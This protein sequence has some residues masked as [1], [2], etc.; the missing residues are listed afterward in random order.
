[1]QLTITLLIILITYAANNN[2]PDNHDYN[3]KRNTQTIT[4]EKPKFHVCQKNCNQWRPASIFCNI[5]IDKN[6]V[7]YNYIIYIYTHIY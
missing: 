7:P 5:F 3:H 6:F 2:I 1:M 4:L